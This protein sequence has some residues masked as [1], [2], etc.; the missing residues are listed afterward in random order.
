M[1]TYL[2]QETTLI[3]QCYCKLLSKANCIV[4]DCDSDVNKCN[5]E[6]VQTYLFQKTKL[7]KQCYFKLLSKANCVVKDCNCD[8]D[9][10]NTG[11]KPHYF[12]QLV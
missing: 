6:R 10:C 9:K 7:I 8:V 4:K 11:S 2:L 5:T 3:K 12:K 1:Q